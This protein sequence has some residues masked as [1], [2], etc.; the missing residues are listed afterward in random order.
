MNMIGHQTIGVNLHAECF[1]EF[2]QI[3]EITLIVFRTRK[4]YLTVMTALYYMVQVVWYV[5]VST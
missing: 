1:L 2:T 5:E 4:H 3:R